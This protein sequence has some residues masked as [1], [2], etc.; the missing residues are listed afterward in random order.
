[1]QGLRF[2]FPKKH[3]LVGKK[4][5]ETLLSKGEAFFVFPYRII[6]SFVPKKNAENDPIKIVIAVPK[7]K[8]KL[9]VQRNSVKRITREAY[10]LQ[11]QLLLPSLLINNVQLQVMLQYTQ[12]VDLEIMIAKASLKKILTTIQKK[13]VSNA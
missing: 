11:Q 4:N 2:T 1:M 8:C 9:A 7:R 5:I 6:Y 3:R 13:I 12:T 10:R